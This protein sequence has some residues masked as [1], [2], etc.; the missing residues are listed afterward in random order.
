MRQV[1]I[2]V[3]LCAAA[4][5]VCAASAGLDGQFAATTLIETGTLARFDPASAVLTVSTARGEQ[6]F[7]IGPKT[8]VREGWHKIDPIA[9]LGLVGRDIRVRYV[10]SGGRT[11]VQSVSVSSAGSRKRGEM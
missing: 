6:R 5:V 4:T 2:G 3:V 10:E 9:L 1:A 7:T 8:R 11:T